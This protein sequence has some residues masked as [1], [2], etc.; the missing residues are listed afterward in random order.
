M[1][2]LAPFVPSPLG[3]TLLWRCLYT[4]LAKAHL[5][6]L[7]DIGPR[8][9]PCGWCAN[10]ASLIG[11]ER[12]RIPLGRNAGALCTPTGAMGTQPA[13]VGNLILL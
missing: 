11:R 2:S 1:T 5:S 9:S 7:W 6:G 4:K 13:M 12:L 10:L 8:L 3:M